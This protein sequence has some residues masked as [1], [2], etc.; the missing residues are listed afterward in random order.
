[1]GVEWRALEAGKRDVRLTGLVE[2]KRCGLR[3]IYPSKDARREALVEV[4]GGI[5]LKAGRGDWSGN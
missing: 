4:D 3:S 2:F 1:M 5:I